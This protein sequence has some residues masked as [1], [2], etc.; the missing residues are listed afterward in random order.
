MEASSDP[1][2]PQVLDDDRVL[3]D[4]SRVFDF[5]NTPE[6]GWSTQRRPFPSGLHGPAMV[7][8][9]LQYIHFEPTVHPF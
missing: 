2:K 1:S 8:I 5:L 9:K 4:D 6:A 3:D 7:T